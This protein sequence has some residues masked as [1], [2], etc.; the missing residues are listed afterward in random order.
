MKKTILFLMTMSLFFAC[1]KKDSNNSNTG[2]TAKVYGKDW[3]STDYQANWVGKT[4]TISGVSSDGS[5]IVINLKDTVEKAYE[6]RQLANLQQDAAAYTPKDSLTYSNSYVGTGGTV[7]I[8]SINKNDKTI[9]GAFSLTLAI[10]NGAKVTLT[11]GVFNNILYTKGL[12]L[13]AGNTFS[14]TITGTAWTPVTISGMSAFGDIILNI[15][16]GSKT[17]SIKI[18]TSATTGTVSLSPNGTYAVNY[19]EGTKGYNSN[20]G[21]LTITTY[22]TSTKRIEGSFNA[23]VL[24]YSNSSNSKVLTGTFAISY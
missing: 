3:I 19:A 18:P 12:P 17:I 6:L 4:I 15:T 14:G 5:N 7:T 20:S 23:T 22:N 8:S 10:A 24:D 16:D 9:S 21:S 2:I 11:N 1:T 13:I